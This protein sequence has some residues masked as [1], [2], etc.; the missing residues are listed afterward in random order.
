MLDFHSRCGLHTRAVTVIRDPLSEGFRHFVTSMPAP[1]A[2]GWS[3]SPGGPRTHWKAPPCHGAPPLRA[4]P[5]RRGGGRSPTNKRRAP[6]PQSSNLRVGPQLPFHIVT[7]GPED[8]ASGAAGLEQGET[9]AQLL[10][11]ACEGHLFGGGYVDERVMAVRNVEGM[12]AVNGEVAD[13][14]VSTFDAGQPR[15]AVRQRFH[16]FRIGRVPEGVGER[17]ERFDGGRGA[18]RGDLLALIE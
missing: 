18:G 10:A 3:E 6:S 16:A 7:A 15:F 11:S 12:T 8:N 2:S 5:S 13:V 9:F 14:F 4:L 1:V 17:D